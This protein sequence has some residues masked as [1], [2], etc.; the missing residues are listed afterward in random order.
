MAELKCPRCGKVLAETEKETKV[1]QDCGCLF[2]IID[3]EKGKTKSYSSI[4]KDSRKMNYKFWIKFYSFFLI[5]WSI[6]TVYGIVVGF[7]S[8]PNP[9]KWIILVISVVVYAIVFT[10]IQ[11][12]INLIRDVYVLKTK[13]EELE[14]NKKPE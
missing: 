5:L 3:P 10:R 6:L 8:A 1:C 7:V 13:F 12:Q 9:W 11:F 2:G 14:K 4:I